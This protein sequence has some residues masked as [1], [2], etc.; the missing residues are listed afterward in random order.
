MQLQTSSSSPC[1][2]CAQVLLLLPLRNLALK[3]I[4]RLCDLAQAET[5]TD[6]IQNKQR[7]LEEFGDPD[8]GD[9]Q[10]ATAKLLKSTKPA[11][12]Q[13]LFAG[14]TDDFFRLGIKFTRCGC[15]ITTCAALAQAIFDIFVV[16]TFSS[17]AACG[18]RS[19]LLCS[20]LQT[21]SGSFA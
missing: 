8:A 4:L 14:N 6:S 5:R 9:V 17:A 1:C 20:C 19:R 11:T 16:L 7:L 3:A 15:V 21:A 2:S 12:H 10:S 18:N 13:A